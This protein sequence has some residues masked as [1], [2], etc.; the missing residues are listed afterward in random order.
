MTTARHHVRCLLAGEIREGSLVGE[1]VHIGPDKIPLQDVTLLAPCTPTKI[2][3]VGRNY[4]EHAAEMN[5]PLPL[6]PLLF[7]KPLSAL[8]HHNGPIVYPPLTSELH[9]EGELA[10]VIGRRCRHVPRADALGVVAGY[11][12]CNDVTARDLQRSDGQW[13]RAKGCDSF[14]PLGPCLVAGL[15]ASNLRLRTYHN[16]VLRQDARTSD[17]I[18]DIPYLIEYISA[19]FTLEAG[20]VITTGTP[21]GVGPIHPGD[22]IEVH[23]DE[24]GVLRNPVVTG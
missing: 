13:A 1:F 21:R 17:L 18:F 3:G 11:T 12:L 16:G 4:A 8:N 15:D 22:V 20:D 2:I 23:I 9:Y 5:N 24:I 14:A 19:A 6:A 7:F 10:V